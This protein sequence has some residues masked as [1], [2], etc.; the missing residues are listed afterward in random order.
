MGERVARQNSLNCVRRF[1]T[2]SVFT[3]ENR[4]VSKSGANA[5]IADYPSSDLRE[6]THATKIHT[7]H[8]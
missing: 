7:T 1:S 6:P 3:I 5:G 4:D 8:H 2:E